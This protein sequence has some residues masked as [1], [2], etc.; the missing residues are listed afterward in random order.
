MLW[1]NASNGEVRAWE[2]ESGVKVG[3]AL[4]RT[5]IGPQYRVISTL[6][7]DDDGDDDIVWRDE[8]NGNVYA[9]RMQGLVRESGSF[10]R[11]V[12]LQWRVV[13]P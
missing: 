2:I 10:V 4:V 7:T 1:H 12:A 13:N 9:W 6:D 8:T 5:G 3:G 11:N